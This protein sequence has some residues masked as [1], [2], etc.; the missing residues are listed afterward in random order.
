[1]MVINDELMTLIF[2]ECRLVERKYM[3][4]V[5]W[6]K[7]ACPY[8]LSLIT[9]FTEQSPGITERKPLKNINIRM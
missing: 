7:G 8:V 5:A 3:Y 1:M 6:A 9:G 4:T 2:L